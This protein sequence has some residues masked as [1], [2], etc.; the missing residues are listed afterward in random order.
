MIRERVHGAGSGAGPSPG[1]EPTTCGC[2][3]AQAFGTIAVVRKNFSGW[4][5][6]QRWLRRRKRERVSLSRANAYNGIAARYVL[7]TASEEIRELT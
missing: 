2:L 3:T 7:V 6:V 1:G 5:G 4:L